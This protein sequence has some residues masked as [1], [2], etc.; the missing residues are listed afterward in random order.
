MDD[1]PSHLAAI[2]PVPSVIVAS[3]EPVPSRGSMRM[4]RTTPA[5]LAVGSGTGL[6][7]GDDTVES[8]DPLSQVL[9]S[10]VSSRPRESLDQATQQCHERE[11]WQYRP[12]GDPLAGRGG[13]RGCML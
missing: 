8:L 6:V 7:Y 4:L 9:G 5:T 3:I 2:W 13:M 1:R 10:D 11:V 12:A